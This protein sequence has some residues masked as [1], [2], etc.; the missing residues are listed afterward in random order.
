MSTDSFVLPD[1]GA[2]ALR[3]LGLRPTVGA[4]GGLWRRPHRRARGRH[5][6][7]R[8]VR[9]VGLLVVLARLWFV[10]LFTA[11]RL[12]R[13][14]RS[15]AVRRWARQLLHTLCV[16]V[17]TRGHVPASDAPLLVVAN[18]TSWLDS[19]ALNTVST[20]RFVAKSEVRGWPIIGTIAE[21]FGAIFIKRGCPRGAA[22]TVAVLAQALIDA[23][24][25][26]GFPEGTTS[27]GR[28]VLRFYPA[29][30]QA[31]VLSGARVQ[32]VAIRY[33]A[34]D[35]APTDAAAYVGDMTVFE[36]LR[37]MLREPRLTAELIFCAP[38]DSTGRTRR[39][40]AALAH[41]AIAA[42]LGFGDDVD[43][44]SPL[45]RAA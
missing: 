12:T 32:P 14:Q 24:P 31:A 13:L 2:A 6:W 41:A 15:H 27:E 45:R 29:M 5:A 28:G 34:A 9:F 43:R 4:G 35:G 36:S 40:L 22:R 23:E 37:R 39:E 16:E 8:G 30:F 20:A 17:R 42:A 26:G 44:S 3:G 7:G 25:V 18:H 38:L 19:Y 1:A 21:R 33:R 11:P 10:A